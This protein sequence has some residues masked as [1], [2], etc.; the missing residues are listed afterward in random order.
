M[1]VHRDAP[2]FQA[3]SKQYNGIPYCVAFRNSDHFVTTCS[4]YIRSRDKL[5]AYVQ[6]EKT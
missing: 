6:H 3:V 4:Y 2:L 1:A 5:N